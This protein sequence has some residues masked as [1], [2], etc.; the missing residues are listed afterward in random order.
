MYI[1]S[2]N[3]RST[4]GPYVLNVVA[5]LL[6]CVCQV[7]SV[8]GS[9][10]ESH[11][12]PLL[13]AQMNSRAEF[14]GAIG[15]RSC[16]NIA[17]LPAINSLMGVDS[18]QQVLGNLLKLLVNPVST[19]LKQLAQGLVFPSQLKNLTKDMN[20]PLVANTGSL[21]SC[22]VSLMLIK[23]S[24][25]SGPLV[26]KGWPVIVYIVTSLFHFLGC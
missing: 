20:S 24:C 2:Q 17:A 10:F 22:L 14:D 8:R 25:L 9:G 5:V 19:V 26:I 6:R 4:V 7:S 15:G 11:R 3:D 16:H 21:L 18:F 13:V 23:S 1:F 12:N